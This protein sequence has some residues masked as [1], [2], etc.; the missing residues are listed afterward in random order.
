MLRLIRLSDN[1]GLTR[2]DGLHFGF[3]AREAGVGQLA[4][5]LVDRRKLLERE[6]Q[7]TVQVVDASVK[8]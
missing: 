1:L 6:V 7:A 5:A 3:T 4:I 2:Q 8:P